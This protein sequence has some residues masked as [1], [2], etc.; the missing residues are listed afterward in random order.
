M[1]R[2]QWNTRRGRNDD[3]VLRRDDPGAGGRC[4]RGDLA[5]SPQPPPEPRQ[6][7]GP[8]GSD[9]EVLAAE[10]GRYRG[11]PWPCWDPP[12]RARDP[13]LR[14]AASFRRAKRGRAAVCPPHPHA[15]CCRRGDAPPRPALSRLRGGGPPPSPPPGGA[16][17]ALGAG[18]AIPL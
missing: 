10:P 6:A 8:R 18:D 1:I 3:G 14:P 9:R 2:C 7:L 4:P 13:T 17:G 5:P 16:Q 15:P 11:E 12:P